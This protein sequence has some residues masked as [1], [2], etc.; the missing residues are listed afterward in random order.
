M[1]FM[2]KLISTLTITDAH[3]LSSSTYRNVFLHRTVKRCQMCPLA[4]VAEL[5][6]VELWNF[7][8]IWS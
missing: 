7:R 5:L 1:H 4:A 2:L 3:A 6:V 8:C